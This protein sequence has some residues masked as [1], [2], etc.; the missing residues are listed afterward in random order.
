MRKLNKATTV[1]VLVVL[2]V[3]SW[4]L[5][6]QKKRKTPGEEVQASG[7]R[8]REAEFYFTEGEKYFIL[9]DYAKA[10]TYYER[11]LEF[12]PN[13]G[14]VHY[15][16]AEVLMQSNQPDDLQRASLSIENALKYEKKNKYFYLLAANIY[17]S[18]TR[19][20]K[21]AAVYELML[22][23]VKGTDEH[24]YDLAAI[25]QYANRIDDAIKTYNR[26]EA[27]LGVNE[28]SALQK[29]RLYF[30]QGKIKEAMAE[31]EKLIA[32]FPAEERYIMGFTEIL[33]QKG[34]RAEAIRYL[35][36]FIEQNPDALNTK[37]LL[38]GIYR[39]NNEEAKARP[40]LLTLFG[41]K[42]V[43]LR[44]KLLILG[45]YNA[46]LNTNK[47]KNLKDPDKERFAEQLFSK[48]QKEHPGD[49]NVHIVGGDLFLSIGKNREA[50]KEYLEAIKT[51]DVNFEV[52]ENLLYLE[53]QLA[54][55]DQMILHSDQALE[56]FPNH[57]MIFYFN[58]YAHLRKRNFTNA[59]ASFEQAKRLS[60]ANRS[61]MSEVHGLLG[62][63]YY[64]D[65]NFEKSV[66]S[67]EEALALE[68][69]NSTVL[70]NFSFYLAIRKQDLERAERM[71][72]QLIKNNPD[73]P[74]Y[75]DTHAWV[76]YNRGKFKEAR[77]VIEK[78][79]SSGTAAA[80]HLEHYGD[81]L[82][83]L[84]EIDAAVA[85]WEKARGLNANNEAL[86]KK[87]ANRKMYE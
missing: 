29:Q 81:I 18:L 78:A 25:Y 16:I 67:F 19:F 10:L 71:S 20:D 33:S 36:K 21:A 56:L 9:E 68:P 79:V 1:C 34:H 66:K 13:N 44:S 11:T 3:L 87:I 45:A 75:L 32:T 80:A 72:T 69:E 17:T 86:N 39:D 74:N 6:A 38:A 54:L 63:A 47:A 65:G 70:N 58:G 30:E 49:E 26:A 84:G 37:M 50:Q 31:G 14:T 64:G 53:N 82:F 46:E 22:S 60:A 2:M 48:L 52:W 12:N 51:G 85:Q 28:V 43:E 24:L 76:L 4:P 5:C 61:L 15:K 59:I 35:E 27:V 55:Y 73:N 7:T 83:K 40:L 42:D 62:E 57:G 41:N 8:M 23:E 77:K